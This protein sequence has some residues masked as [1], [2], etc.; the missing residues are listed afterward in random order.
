M[1]GSRSVRGLRR[2]QGCGSV[3]EPELAH[4][5]WCAKN[6]SQPFAAYTYVTKVSS[7]VNLVDNGYD[8]RNKACHSPA[9]SHCRDLIGTGDPCGHAPLQDSCVF[10]S[11][12]RCGISCKP[13]HPHGNVAACRAQRCNFVPWGVSAIPS[14]LHPAASG[15]MPEHQEAVEEEK[16][17]WWTIL[18]VR[19][20]GL[21][22]R[23]LFGVVWRQKLNPRQA[24]PV[25]LV[26]ILSLCWPGVSGAK[27]HTQEDH[28]YAWGHQHHAGAGSNQRVTGQ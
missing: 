8:A 25:T 5:I 12:I 4:P 10:P 22:C 28:L 13:C 1:A 21:A 27:V 17:L 26:K 18:Q 7:C 3:A 11:G 20:C 6:A 16:P 15:V 24:A 14:V 19:S 23:L 2:L 9:A